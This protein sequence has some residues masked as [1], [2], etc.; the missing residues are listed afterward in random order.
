MSIELSLIQT[1]QNRRGELQRFVESLNSQVG[2]DFNKIQLIFVDQENNRD[3]FDKLNPQIKFD[4]IKYH[5]CS[6]SHARNVAIQH[7]GGRY[8]AF[9]D[10]DCWYEPDTLSKVLDYFEADTYDGVNCKGCNAEGKLTSIFPDKAAELTMTKR[11][12]A[13]SYTLFFRFNPEVRFDENMGVGSPYNIGSGEETDYLLTL[14]EKGYKVYYDPNIIVHHP[15]GDIYDKDAIL[16]KTY[17]YARG[18][19]Y[20]LRKHNFPTS[21]KLSFIC[22][23]LLGTVVNALKLNGY[24]SHKSFNRFKGCLEGYFFKTEKQ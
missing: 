6:L 18:A 20:F 3:V 11:C 13:I 15:T 7:V 16:R 10:D 19:G 17:S 22:R 24:K 21:Y 4:Y 1:S 5:H 12:A 14:M 2:I 9:P 23:P 8:V